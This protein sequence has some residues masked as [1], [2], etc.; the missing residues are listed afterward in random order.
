MVGWS[1]RSIQRSSCTHFFPIVFSDIGMVTWNQPQRGYLH[2]GKHQTLQVNTLPTLSK[3]EGRGKIVIVCRRRDILY[4]NPPHTHTQNRTNKWIQQDNRIPD[5][6]RN[7]PNQGVLVGHV[8]L[9]V[10]ALTVANQSPLS[11]E[12]SRQEYWSGLPFPSPNQGIEK[13]MCWKL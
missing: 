13:F 1:Q 5:Q 8:R 3:S 11:M 7:K 10:T 9:F 6:T 12:F 2:P 4:S